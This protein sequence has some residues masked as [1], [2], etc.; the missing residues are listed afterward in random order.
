MP[1][2]KHTPGPWAFTEGRKDM[3]QASAVHKAGDKEFL[4]A[5]V[6]CENMNMAQRTEDIANARL[7]AASPDLLVAL[8]GFLHADPDVFAAELAAARAA[9]AKATGK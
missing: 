6:I 5:H 9:I 2:T 7:M 3:R 1:E 4:I 8:Q